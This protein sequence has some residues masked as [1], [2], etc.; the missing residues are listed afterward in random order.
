MEIR[1]SLDRMTSFLLAKNICVLAT[2][3]GTRPHCSLMAYITDK[4]GREVYMFTRRNSRKY[5]NVVESRAVS[6]LID[7][8]GE[9]DRR[10]T[11][12]LT[13]SATFDPVVDPGKKS[14]IKRA[15]LAAHPHLSELIDHPDAELLRFRIDSL[16]LLDGPNRSY[17][18]E[19]EA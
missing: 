16:L 6:I 5:A 11:Q 18:A 15:F 17:F 8:R 4:N 10:R 12:A 1:M 19:V 3:S 14:R 13:V 2:A 9:S 7:D